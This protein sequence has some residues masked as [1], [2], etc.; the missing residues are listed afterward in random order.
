MAELTSRCQETNCNK[1]QLRNRHYCATHNTV[2][3]SSDVE[4]PIQH[5]T[6]RVTLGGLKRTTCTCSWASR[7][8]N[9]WDGADR[10]AYA[11]V[12]R[13]IDPSWTPQTDPKYP[14]HTATDSVQC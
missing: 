13:R 7:G 5:I 1:R 11:H 3:L 12:Q 8:Y 10:E 4:G 2:Q 9:Q 6:E 14:F